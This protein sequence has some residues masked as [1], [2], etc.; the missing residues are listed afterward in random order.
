MVDSQ[1]LRRLD[2]PAYC[3]KLLDNGLLAIAGG[4]GTAKTG[5]GNSIELGFLEYS[6]E[7]ASGAYSASFKLIH[8]FET[9]D[10]IMK[11]VSFTCEPDSPSQHHRSRLNSESKHNSIG[12]S[13]TAAAYHISDLYLAGALDNSIEIFKIE[14]SVEKVSD[15]NP[16]E[17]RASATVRNVAAIQLNENASNI[18][19]KLRHF[20]KQ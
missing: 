16:T 2:F 4:G 18:P 15:S 17:Y 8:K 6:G 3:V 10:A 13:T 1:V 19:S 14:P 11:F 7:Q 20:F 5:V 9:H 12:T